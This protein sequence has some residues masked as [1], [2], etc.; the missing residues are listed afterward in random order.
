MN[1][2][3]RR[4][5]CALGACLVGVFAASAR[6]GTF[7]DNFTPAPSPLWNNYFGNWTAS[8]GE[9]FAQ[10][11]DNN[12]L[13]TSQLPFA[14]GDFSMTV[15]ANNLTDGGIWIHGDGT[16]QNGI[17]LVLGGNGYGQGVRGGNAGDSIY[18]ATVTNGTG[19]S[20]TFDEVDGEFVPGDTYTITVTGAGD[21]YSAYVNGGSTPVTQFVTSSF[22]TGQIG[23]YDDQPNL[24][25]GGSGPSMTFSNFSLTASSVPEPTSIALLGVAT[26]ALLARSRSRASRF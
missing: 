17:L 11:A 16:N 7:T 21:V 22:A 6:A 4:L 15:T 26:T 12:P 23:L 3:I 25:S 2:S 8:S 5:V 24:N 19:S 14:V 10:D 9:Y 13:A 1:R 18:W 20:S